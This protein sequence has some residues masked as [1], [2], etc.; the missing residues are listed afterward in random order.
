MF[1][2]WSAYYGDVKVLRRST[3]GSRDTIVVE[4]ACPP[5]DPVFADV[6]ADTGD[7]LRTRSRI[8]NPGGVK[9]PIDALYTDF[10][11]VGGVRVPHRI[12][13]T[14]PIT[15]EVILAFDHFERS[16]ELPDDTFP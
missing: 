2:D 11:D 7:V 1:D 6:D 3:V 10:R 5:L 14:H 13:T 4:L 16:V 9:L 15:G 12:T 8:L